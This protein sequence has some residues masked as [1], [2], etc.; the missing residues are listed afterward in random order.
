MNY[1]YK[2]IK[3]D[4]IIVTITMSM[5]TE[6]YNKCLGILSLPI[7]SRCFDVDEELNTT[8]T[9]GICTVQGNYIIMN[10]DGYCG[11]CIY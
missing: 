9:T 3:Y 6:L 8:E 10:H 2:M 7:A 11:P 5:L 4:L 1:I